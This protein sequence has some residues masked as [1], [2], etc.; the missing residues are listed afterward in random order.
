MFTNPYVAHH[1]VDPTR[2]IFNAQ[3]LH[4]PDSIFSTFFRYGQVIET[5]RGKGIFQPAIDTA[6]EKL[7]RGEWVSSL[8]L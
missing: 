3:C 1:A 2:C 6:I 8:S 5:F 4:P 7:N